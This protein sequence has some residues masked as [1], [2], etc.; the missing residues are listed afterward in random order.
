VVSSRPRVLKPG[1]T[2]AL[3]LSLFHSFVKLKLI[4]KDADDV[5]ITLSQGHPRSDFE[6][7]KTTFPG[8]YPGASGGIASYGQLLTNQERAGAWP[9]PDEPFLPPLSAYKYWW[10]PREEALK[11]EPQED[12]TRPHGGSRL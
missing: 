4:P 6:L 1:S 11:L 10:V 8:Q 5:F 3:S 9:T 2:I 12:D 7:C